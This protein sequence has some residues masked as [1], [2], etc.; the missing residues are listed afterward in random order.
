MRYFT[1]VQNLLINIAKDPV[2]YP[3][4]EGWLPAAGYFVV[5][6]WNSIRDS[7][8]IRHVAGASTNMLIHSVYAGMDCWVHC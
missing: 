8:K 2:F 7:L 1:S 6:C 5:L 4:T 3:G